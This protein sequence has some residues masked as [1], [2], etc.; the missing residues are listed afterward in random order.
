FV[1]EWPACSNYLP[2]VKVGSPAAPR[3]FLT[4]LTDNLSN[5]TRGVGAIEDRNRFGVSSRILTQSETFIIPRADSAGKPISYRLEPFAPTVAI[6][7]RSY[8]NNP[9]LIP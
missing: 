9:P 1:P 6:A 4:M 7:D 8:P 3:F 2:I 5:G